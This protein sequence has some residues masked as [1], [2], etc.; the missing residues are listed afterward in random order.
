MFEQEGEG[1]L[2]GDVSCNFPFS[3]PTRTSVKHVSLTKLLESDLTSLGGGHVKW[4]SPLHSL[5][6]VVAARVV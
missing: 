1:H 6:P 2:L 4:A 3:F 5:A